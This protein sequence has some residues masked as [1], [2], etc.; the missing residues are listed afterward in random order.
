MNIAAPRLHR[1]K[2]ALLQELFEALLQGS[3]TGAIRTDQLDLAGPSSNLTGVKD[4]PA[5]MRERA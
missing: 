5:P 1:R 2:R 4:A 3:M